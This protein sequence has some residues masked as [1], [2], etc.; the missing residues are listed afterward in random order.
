MTDDNVHPAS[1]VHKSEHPITCD[2]DIVSDDFWFTK[3]RLEREEVYARLRGGP[4]PL[5]WSRQLRIPGIPDEYQEAGFWALLKRDDI[6]A[7]SL[8]HEAFSASTKKGN[9][10]FRPEMPVAMPDN[11]TSMDPPEHTRSRKMLSYAFTPKAVAR[12]DDIL[13]Q[14]VK[15]IVSEAAQIGGEFN[16][17]TEVS[18]KLPMMTIA[19]LVGVPDEHVTAFVDAGNNFVDALYGHLPDGIDPMMYIGTQLQTMTQ[20]GV[21]LVEHRRKHPADDLATAMANA[22]FDGQQVS[23]EEIAG[24]M[25]LMSVAGNDTTKQTTSHTMYQLWRNPDQKQW[26]LEDYDARI[27]QAVEEFVRHA[28][29]VTMFPRTLTRDVEMRGQQLLAGDKVL[30]IYMSG[31]R[32]EEIWPD[33]DKFDIRRELHPNV[34]FGGGGIHYC[35]GNQIA[36]AQLRTLFREILTTLPGLEVVGEPVELKSMLINGITD[37]PVRVN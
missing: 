4:H 34:A 2:E 29:P 1:L 27:R 35:L 25:L 21:E 23:V 7:A 30:M 28:S 36:R 17:V 37:L 15:S 19:D 12:L 32:D 20:I 26:L 13:Q 3:S 18:A 24:V 14:R 6:A 5:C 22:E 8:N 11:L 9:T 16:F 33:A 31:N 10:P